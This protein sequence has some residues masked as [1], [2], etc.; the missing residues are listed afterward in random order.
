MA[1]SPSARESAAAKRKFLG[2]IKRAVVTGSAKVEVINNEIVVTSLSSGDVLYTE[3]NLARFLPRFEAWLEEFK[4]P[5]AVAQKVAAQ[6]TNWVE[7]LSV[8]ENTVKAPE[9]KKGRK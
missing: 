6:R 3:K 5:S 2:V 1:Y 9:P 8:L 4:N 7:K